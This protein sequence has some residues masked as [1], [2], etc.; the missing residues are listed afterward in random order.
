MATCVCETEAIP[1]ANCAQRASDERL[2]RLSLPGLATHLKTPVGRFACGLVSSTAGWSKDRRLVSC[3][4][5]LR[6][7][8]HRAP[9]ARNSLP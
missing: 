7:S 1:C 2:A 5:C 4:S 6:C 9:P 8:R 3:K